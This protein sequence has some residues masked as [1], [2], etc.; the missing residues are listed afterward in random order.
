ME[1]LYEKAGLPLVRIP[2]RPT[3]NTNEL[4]VLF[5]T[6]LL[7]TQTS[8]P[9]HPAAGHSVPV[10]SPNGIP[11][12]KSIQNPMPEPVEGLSVTAKRPA[13]GQPPFCPKCGQPMVLRTA[14]VGVNKG[15][16]FWGCV[17]YPKCKTVIAVD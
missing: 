15:R 17:N 2:V 16:Q 7:K 1:D 14:E 4:G 6:A 12:T 8:A 11:Q 5:K 10:G 3:Y 13:D 9:V